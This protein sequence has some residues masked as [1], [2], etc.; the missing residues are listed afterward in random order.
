MAVKFAF[1]KA[2]LCLCGINGKQQDFIY[3]AAQKAW[4]EY[5]VVNYKKSERLGSY[6]LPAAWD[7]DLACM[8]MYQ[9]D[10]VCMVC[11]ESGR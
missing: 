8:G 10:C 9:Q 5:V 3:T 4:T 2:Y 11:P 6:Q 1:Y 7:G